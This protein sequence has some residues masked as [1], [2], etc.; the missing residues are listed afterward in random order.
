MCKAATQT[1][2]RRRLPSRSLQDPLV[3]SK[4]QRH[5]AR[6]GLLENIFTNFFSIGKIAAEKIAREF[7]F[8]TEKIVLKNVRLEKRPLKNDLV[9]NDPLQ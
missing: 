6:M 8:K 2:F 4:R 9:K 1:L 7:F 3:Q 5:G